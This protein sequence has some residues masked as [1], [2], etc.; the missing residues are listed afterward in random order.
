LS[1]STSARSSHGR[2]NPVGS[3]IPI[4]EIEPRHLSAWRHLA[5]RAVEPNPFLEPDCVLP[6]VRNLGEPDVGLL[7]VEDRDREWLA[8]MPVSSRLIVRRTR[9]PAFTAW[10][11]VY[12]CLGTPLVAS[13]AVELATERLLEHAL[14]ASRIGVVVLPW[15]GDDGPVAT[16]LL[17]ALERSGRRPALHR[18]FERAVMRRATVAS[19]ADALISSR[20]RRD[21]HRL[22]RRLAET[23]D[24]PLEV[25]DVSEAA[26]A[27]DEFL[28]LE[29]SGWKGR[30]GTALS[31]CHG[32]A[33]FFR[34]LCDG[35]RS[36]GRLQLLALGSAERTVSYKCNLLTDDAVFCFKIAHDESFGRYRPGLQLEVRM[37]EL[38][39]DKMDHAWMD[40][41]AAP[42]SELFKTF[43]PEVRRIGSYVVAAN[44]A[45]GWTIGHSAAHFATPWGERR[46]A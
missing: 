27:V 13:S 38:F 10:R 33:E 37:L 6:A 16:A 30:R 26:T 11:H 7:V 2:R 36:R 23:L 28:A 32:H 31:S 46:S 43:W 9:V 25:R 34:Q 1:A 42:D 15:L 12:S 22:S 21:L 24:A 39:R 5:E 8:C 20:H 44:P 41:C 19:G 17:A 45:V 29:V 40:S 3:L 18:S 14:R 4:R 35:F